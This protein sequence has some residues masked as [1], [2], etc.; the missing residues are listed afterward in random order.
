MKPI[1]N[2]KPIIKKKYDIRN[3]CIAKHEIG[4]RAK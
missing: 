2:S 1:D 4:Y 3:T